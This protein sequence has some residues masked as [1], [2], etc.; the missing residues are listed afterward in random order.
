MAEGGVLKIQIVTDAYYP[1]RT[2]AA[3]LLRDLVKTFHDSSHEVFVITPNAYQ[4]ELEVVKVID[5][6]HVLSF[7]T[8]QT[9]DVGFIRRL[10]AELINP[11][12]IWYRLRRLDYFKKNRADAIIWYSPSIFWGPLIYRLKKYSQCNSYLVLRDIFPDWA[13][14]LGILKKGPLYLFFQ[15]ITRYQYSLADVI[16]LQSPNNL[17][18]FKKR[19]LHCKAKL[20]VLWNWTR[21]SGGAKCSIRLDETSLKGRTICVYAGNVGLAQGKFALIA[22]IEAL[23]SVDNTGF[24]LVGRGTEMESL[25]LELESRNIKNVLFFDEIDPDE[26][27]DLYK[28]CNIGIVALHPKHTTHNIPG[29]FTSYIQAGLPVF[30]I[31]N[32]GNDLIQIIHQ[33]KVGIVA[34]SCD[35]LTLITLAKELISDINSGVDFRNRSQDILKRYFSATNAAKQIIQS[36]GYKL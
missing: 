34:S 20:E 19:N 36:L 10:V 3:V 24:V 2:S 27:P 18:Y 4:A 35:Q 6:A 8:Y 31:V 12:I 9:K 26:I 22:A 14:D 28:Q 5:G 21:E 1:M 23:S 32:P 16:G 13:L 30:A 29:K 33:Y 11:W 17:D 7:K 15:A 25:A